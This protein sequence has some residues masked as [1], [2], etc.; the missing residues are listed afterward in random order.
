[1]L[2]HAGFQLSEITETSPVCTQD[3][4]G[5]ISPSALATFM[6]EAIRYA[7]EGGHV[8]VKFAPKL[9][10]G[11]STHPYWKRILT[12][13][14]DIDKPNSHFQNQHHLADTSVIDEFSKLHNY[15]TTA[16]GH[17]NVKTALGKT[18]REISLTSALY[19]LNDF[20][21]KIKEIAFHLSPFWLIER[22]EIIVKG[23]SLHPGLEVSHA[24]R[25]ELIEN[26]IANIRPDGEHTILMYKDEI[27]RLYLQMQ[28]CLN[29]MVVEK[30]KWYDDQIKN[31]FEQLTTI[32][33]AISSRNSINTANDADKKKSQSKAE[34]A[35]SVEALISNFHTHFGEILGFQSAGRKEIQM[36]SI[37]DQFNDFEIAIERSYAHR[38][39]YVD[40]YM[41]RLNAGLSGTKE[42]SDILDQIQIIIA[43]LNGS[44]LLKK[45]IEINS[46]NFYQIQLELKKILELLD[47]VHVFLTQFPVMLHWNSFKESLDV[48]TRKILT[49]LESF[50]S[51][52]WV[53]IFDQ[54]LEKI[55]AAKIM[56]PLIPDNENIVKKAIDS[57][58]TLWQTF[59]V[60]DIQ[61]INT[62]NQP[63]SEE[64]AP[65]SFL[66]KME[67]WVRRKSN[68]DHQNVSHLP[69]MGKFVLTLADESSKEVSFKMISPD[70]KTWKS[71]FEIDKIQM[72]QNLSAILNRMDE[73]PLTERFGV[74]KT[75]AY[76]ILGLSSKVRV[77]QSKNANILSLLPFEITDVLLE[78][79]SHYGLKEFKGR[80]SV[81]DALIESLL[82]TQRK[83][84]LFLF[85]GL[86]NDEDFS[87][88]ETQ[89]IIIEK[90]KTI[91]FEVHSL[92]SKDIINSG[93]KKQWTLGM[94]ALLQ[95]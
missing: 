57:Q 19:D 37:E 11:L 78:R 52:L 91:G 21:N 40:N 59:A 3:N 80:T 41:K 86:V 93:D 64:E 58:T 56:H 8:E 35:N 32:Q 85:N 39:N 14:G 79:L 33:L 49:H 24:Y 90:F 43:D 17:L 54:A 51:R 89:N 61:A 26:A 67:G 65:T 15:F 81:E 60:Q 72:V 38:F 25:Q 92:W 84:L 82:E 44:G 10:A 83:Q 30:E 28:A 66:K 76:F 13:L 46:R 34:N 50:P 16:F 31:A 7:K 4:S 94:D 63:P 6:R 5:V 88:L 47:E 55:C 95:Q 68:E 62:I 9:L 71:Q 69:G 23:A 36:A 22:R 73:I 70:G 29:R 42:L 45:V 2:T 74:A 27:N 12:S 87:D 53:D 20:E 18:I 75:M 48:N 1:M 77:F